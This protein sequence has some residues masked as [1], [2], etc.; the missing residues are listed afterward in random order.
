MVASSAEYQAPRKQVVLVNALGLPTGLLVEHLSRRAADQLSRRSPESA[1][2]ACFLGTTIPPVSSQS[3]VAD[4]SQAIERGES[5]VLAMEGYRLWRATVESPAEPPQ[6]WGKGMDRLSK[7]D[8]FALDRQTFAFR[9]FELVGIA[10][11]VAKT[12]FHAEW[13]GNVLNRIDKD[14]QLS[15]RQ[16]LFLG[17]A[18]SI[19]RLQLGASKQLP[20][21][22]GSIGLGELSTAIWLKAEFDGSIRFEGLRSGEQELQVLLRRALL[23]SV[24]GI[25]GVDALV[26]AKVVRGAIANSVTNFV[27][28]AG[29]LGLRT[30]AAVR[31]VVEICRRFDAS[32]RQIVKRHDSRSTLTITDEYDVQDL[33]HS[34]LLSRFSDVRAEEWTPSYAGKSARTDF[35]LK[36]EELFIEAKKTRKGLRDREVTEQLAIDVGYYRQHQYCRALVCFV[37]DPEHL[38]Q[39][40]AAVEDDLSGI[41]DGLLVQVVVCPGT[42]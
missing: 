30:K 25:D 27:A 37:Y 12:G 42:A 29:K 41:R 17:L 4:E 38:I 11:G 39:N 3:S 16:S 34:L 22:V 24:D 18:R 9:P 31:E 8:P 35:L 6:P 19:V 2:A 23:E 20:V 13:L 15:L 5:P 1:F 21:D 26:V 10:A 40:P 28:E 36:P 7:K 32:A 33:L 14:H